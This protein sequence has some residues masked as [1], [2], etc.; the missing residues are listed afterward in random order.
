MKSEREMFK[1]TLIGMGYHES[2]FSFDSQT[3]MYALEMTQ[4]NW[5]I[6]QASASREGCKLVPVDTHYKLDD[7]GNVI[8]KP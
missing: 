6:W 3:G 7:D 8:T 1:A 5:C 4:E 2:A